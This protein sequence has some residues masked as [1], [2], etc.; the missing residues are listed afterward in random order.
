MNVFVVVNFSND[1]RCLF[2]HACGYAIITSRKVNF[3]TKLKCKKQQ[4]QKALEES[5]EEEREG[6]HADLY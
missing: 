6:E 1:V 2:I 5:D 3:D 4:Q